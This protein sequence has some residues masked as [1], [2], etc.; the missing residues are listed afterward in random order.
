M[1]RIRTI[2]SQTASDANQNVIIDS[3][4]GIRALLNNTIREVYRQK[5]NDQK[6]IRDIVTRNTVVVT[7]GV[8]ACPDA[9]MREFLHAAQFQDD[10]DS[11]IT[12]YDYNI[13]A[14]SGQNYNQL[15]YVRMSDSNF[16]YTAPSPTLDTYT[17]NLFVTVATFPTFPVSMASAITFPSVSTIDDIVLAGAAAITGKLEYTTI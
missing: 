1:A 7:S 5:S 4:G 6:F 10:N 3:L 11:L 13:D 15:G 8:G 17:G 2:A 16:L 14:D 12:Y 9:V